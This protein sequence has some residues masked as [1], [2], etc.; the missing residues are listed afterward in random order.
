MRP[1]STLDTLLVIAA[2]GRHAEALAWARRRVEE[3]FGPIGLE[4]EPYPFHHTAYYTATMGPDLRKQLW[5]FERLVPLESLATHKVAT[6]QLEEE[7][8]T[9]GQ[10]PEPRPLNLDPGL[11]N[12]GKFMLATT[13]DKDHRIY[14]RD[15]IFAE[16][17][18]RYC[19]KEYVPWA[20]TYADYREDH[21]RDFLNR[22][23]EYYKERLKHWAEQ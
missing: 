2:F 14:L 22:A 21:V 5:V 10:F 6:I 7:L 16:V 18:M 15:G 12:L 17:T 23:R 3:L 19:D 20:W 11:L 1:P 13:K 9:S 8:S 4:S